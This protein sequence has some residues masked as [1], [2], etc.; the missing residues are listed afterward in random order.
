MDP[1]CLAL[2]VLSAIVLVRFLRSV[3]GRR[4]DWSSP[5]SFTCPR[6]GGHE[7]GSASPPGGAH[8]VNCQTDGCPGF[9]GPYEEHVRPCH[10]AWSTGAR[11]AS[12]VSTM[13]YPASQG[14][15]VSAEFMVSQREAARRHNQEALDRERDARWVRVSRLRDWGRTMSDDDFA[16]AQKALER[17]FEAKDMTDLFVLDSG[18]CECGHVNA[19]HYPR[20][21]GFTCACDGCGCVKPTLGDVK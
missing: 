9:M 21:G 19:G 16:E 12:A 2:A 7:F 20:A 1:W 15:P 8:V 10:G 3:R 5:H 6:C 11:A 14:V 4:W 13:G 18:L 17:S